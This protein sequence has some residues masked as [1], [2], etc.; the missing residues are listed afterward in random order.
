M[1]QYGIPDHRV[2]G[3]DTGDFVN[4]CDAMYDPR[5]GVVRMKLGFV[6]TGA[7]DDH[8][9]KRLCILYFSPGRRPG[10]IEGNIDR[11][12]NF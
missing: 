9:K 6:G 3:A 7:E 12:L 5:K 2:N 11:V 1:I 4:A 10:K 8:G